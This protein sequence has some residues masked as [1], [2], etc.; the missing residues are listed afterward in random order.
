MLDD[1]NNCISNY[2][3]AVKQNATEQEFESDWVNMYN[4]YYNKG[5]FAHQM[6]VA[7][8]LLWGGN[9]MID[10]ERKD[11][12]SWLGDATLVEGSG[13]VASFYADDYYADLDAENIV[14]I[15][16][17]TGYGYKQSFEKYYNETGKLY[18]R[19][20]KFLEH[21]SLDEVVQQIS[22][23]LTETYLPWD[24][25][26]VTEKTIP[27]LNFIRNLQNNNHIFYWYY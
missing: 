10:E 13:K 11:L 9:G 17:Q 16:K 20:E 7:A 12:A 22:F 2:K 26:D 8:A 15:M 18:T 14:Y 24:A 5:D 19:A 4:R 6:Y 23:K 21:T 3:A 27:G 1:Y 25:F